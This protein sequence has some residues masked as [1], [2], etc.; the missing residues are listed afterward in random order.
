LYG[1]A[2]LMLSW[3]RLTTDPPVA[4][5]VRSDALLWGRPAI[6]TAAYYPEGF[7]MVTTLTGSKYKAATPVLP[8]TDGI[9]A[10]VGGN[11]A[12][13]LVYP[14]T[15]TASNAVLGPAS[16]RMSI[17]RSNGLFSGTITPPGSGSAIAFGGAIVQGQTNGSGFFRHSGQSGR[18]F[19]GPVPGP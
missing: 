8:F 11:L 19:F 4:S 5:P 1:G 16:L 2:G 10:F 18:V 7:E 17:T 13:N 9:V 3:V 15:L 6:S 12:S 14:V